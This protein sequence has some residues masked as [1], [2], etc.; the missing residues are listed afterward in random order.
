LLTGFFGNIQA[1]LLC[2]L[3]NMRYLLLILVFISN[4]CA[5]ASGP[6]LYWE[7]SATQ[8]KA[9]LHFQHKS[10]VPQTP[11]SSLENYI[12]TED[13]NEDSIHDQEAVALLYNRLAF[14]YTVYHA[15]LSNANTHFVQQSNQSSL[16]IPIYLWDQCF[17]I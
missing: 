15:D 17:L 7:T 4:L 3:S 9:H 12:V 6:I 13:D 1:V 2:T 16:S 14:T 5:A 11:F 10:K 8:S